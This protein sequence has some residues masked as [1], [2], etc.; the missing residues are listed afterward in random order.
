MIVELELEMVNTEVPVS[1]PTQPRDLP[2]CDAMLGSSEVLDFLAQ[3]VHDC[4]P[5]LSPTFQFTALHLAFQGLD[6]FHNSGEANMSQCPTL[7]SHETVIEF[8]YLLI[9]VL[10]GYSVGL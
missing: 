5:E 3:Y 8:H 7:Y 2:L 6:G 1:A 10:S 4:Q 9:T